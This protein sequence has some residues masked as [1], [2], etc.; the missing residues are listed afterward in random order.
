MMIL[1]VSKSPFLGRNQKTVQP[2]KAVRMEEKLTGRRVW[3]RSGNRSWMPLYRTGAICR[4]LLSLKQVSSRASAA[5]LA[6]LA[7]F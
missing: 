4:L 5:S 7:P 6:A 3:F 1:V 2:R